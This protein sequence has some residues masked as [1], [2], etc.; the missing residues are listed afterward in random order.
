MKSFK[1]YFFEAAYKGNIGIMELSKFYSMASDK[2]KIDLKT[3]ISN[4]QMVDAWKL[5]Q[6]KLGVKLVGKEFGN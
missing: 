5:V 2:E 3:L 4:K 6:A 1:T